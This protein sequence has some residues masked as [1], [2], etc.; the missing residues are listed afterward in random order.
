[1]CVYIM[2]TGIQFR[3]KEY[4]SILVIVYIMGRRK[5]QEQTYRCTLHANLEERPSFSV[6]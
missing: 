3:P 6:C 1:M 5:I 2:A 4:S